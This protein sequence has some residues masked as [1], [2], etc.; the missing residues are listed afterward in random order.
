MGEGE[1][2]RRV[3][4][5]GRERKRGKAGGGRE[6]GEKRKGGRRDRER[7]RVIAA[8]M[9][10]KTYFGLKKGSILSVTLLSR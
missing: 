5:E 9:A 6:E 7:R 1:G 10:E 4:R 8:Q 2:R 3:W